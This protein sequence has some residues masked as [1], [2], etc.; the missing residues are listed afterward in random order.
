MGN[1]S[2]TTE[3]E[4]HHEQ[5]KTNQS[6]EWCDKKPRSKPLA[7]PTAAIV[8]K[9]NSMAHKAHPNGPFVRA[10]LRRPKMNSKEEDPTSLTQI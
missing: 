1:V 6:N 2:T 5:S 8:N 7:A 3:K 9:I 10:D 4:M